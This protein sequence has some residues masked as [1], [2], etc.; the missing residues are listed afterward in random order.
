MW[1]SEKVSRQRPDGG[2]QAWRLALS[3]GLE[4]SP[5][6]AVIGASRKHLLE[7]LG[8][9]AVTPTSPFKRG[10]PSP[11]KSERE[12][13]ESETLSLTTNL[14]IRGKRET[15][16]SRCNLGVEPEKLNSTPAPQTPG[17]VPKIDPRPKNATR[18]RPRALRVGGPGKGGGKRFACATRSD[19]S[20][21]R[22]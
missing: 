1:N 4:C 17:A 15:A 16:T 20:K 12:T 19:Y 6:R 2:L 5:N 11:Q 8:C 22:D 13:S 14:L 9:W 10:F 18:K 21:E 7:I 3:Q